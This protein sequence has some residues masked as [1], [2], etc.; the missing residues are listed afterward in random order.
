MTKRLDEL[1]SEACEAAINPNSWAGFYGS[2]RG[3]GDLLDFAKRFPTQSA[4]RG[5]ETF[6]GCVVIA[7]YA[8]WA[9]AQG[10]DQSITHLTGQC[11]RV[12]QKVGDD[13]PWNRLVRAITQ[14]VVAALHYR[15][16]K[17]QQAS[18]SLA[19]AAKHYDS[20]WRISQ[21]KF[22]LKQNAGGED[23]GLTDEPTR[24]LALTFDHTLNDDSG[25][26]AATWMTLHAFLSHLFT[27]KPP[28]PIC[29]NELKVL[30]VGRGGHVLP[31]GIDKVEFPWASL[32]PAFF[33]PLSFGVTDVKTPMRFTLW[34]AARCARQSADLKPDQSL[35]LTVE[36]SPLLHILDG[37]SAGGLFAVGMIATAKE[38]RLDP[39]KTTTCRLWVTP[40]SLIRHPDLL[41]DETL[42]LAFDD[43]ELRPI[44]GVVQK[45]A[46]AWQVQHGLNE[47]LLVP[48]NHDEWF[49]AH[50]GCV[51]PK[52]TPVES[53]GE[54][55]D[56]MWGQQ[57][58]DR[59]LER[60]A[61]AV[62]HRWDD[63]CRPSPLDDN[64]LAD[65]CFRCYVPP[66]LRI[67]GPLLDHPPGEEAKNAGSPRTREEH[68]VPG[69]KDSDEP[70]LNLLALALRSR[71]FE[72]MPKWLMPGRDVVIYDVAGA[73]KTVCSYRL[74]HLLADPNH[75]K[76]LFDRKLPPLV[77]HL[78]DRWPREAVNVGRLLT[79]REV[80]EGRL[81]VE[82]D[83]N[84]PANA[85]L[86]RQT[87]DHAL[88]DRRVVLVVDGLDQF[89]P[90]DREHLVQQYEINPDARLC[91]WVVTSR[92]HTIDDYRGTNRIF[93]D[94]RWMRVRIDPFDDEQQDRYF[95]RVD[96]HGKKIGRRWTE[97]VLDRPAMREL[98]GL[99]MVLWMIRFLIDDADQRGV[100]PPVFESLSRLYVVTSLRLLA[101]AIERNTDPATGQV[102]SR[103]GNRIPTPDGL[104][105][106]QQLTLLEHVLTL[107]AFQMMLITDYNGRREGEDQVAAFERLCKDRFFK[108]LDDKLDQASISTRRKQELEEQLIRDRAHWAWA[109]EVL[110][111][112]ELSH[113]SVTEA[114]HSAGL[115]FRSR[116]MVECHAARYLTRYATSWDI[117]GKDDPDD[118]PV[119][120]LAD[121]SQDLSTFC[122]WN[123]TTDPQWKETWMLAIDMP[124]EPITTHAHDGTFTQAVIDPAVACR[125][126]SA[127]LR[128]PKRYA[129]R[130]IRPTELIYRAWQLFEY[131]DGLM[132]DRSFLVKGKLVRGKG[133]S[134]EDRRDLGQRLLLGSNNRSALVIKLRQDCVA[135][136]RDDKS[137]QMVKEFEERFDTLLADGKRVPIPADQT[138]RDSLLAKWGLRLPRIF[139]MFGKLTKRDVLLAKWGLQSAWEKSRTFIQCPPQSWIDAYESLPEESRKRSNDPRINTAIDGHANESITP[140]RMATTTVTREM[141]RQFDP[142]FESSASKP[143]WGGETLADAI[144]E[145]ASAFGRHTDNDAFPVLCTNFYDAWSFCKWLGP[146]YRLPG[147]FEWEF[148]CRAGTSTLY[149]FG[150][151][152]NGTQ[153]N[154][155][156]N[157]PNAFDSRGN[158]ADIPK[159]PYLQRTTPVGC[160]DYPCNGYGLWDCHGNLWEWSGNW[161][162]DKESFRSLRGGSWLNLASRCCSSYRNDFVP[163]YRGSNF[164]F[165]LV[166]L[167]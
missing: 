156:G 106:A 124:H 42:P 127:L 157:N 41:N 128:Q 92:V 17:P 135:A 38:Q 119:V 142:A 131:D 149:H 122:A 125:S 8:R 96:P 117:F 54:L 126:L 70:L 30:T 44:R 74:C 159:G 11:L 24:L 158:R 16:H 155:D 36:A 6:P 151:S 67:E 113:R 138:Q 129:A 51:T 99:P 165:R 150:N 134:A 9:L 89:P 68:P 64:R 37:R 102:K 166:C 12:L 133:L 161:Y 104:Q 73:G 40:E 121:P 95:D 18:K 78:L 146:Q 163:A 35:R 23:L 56:G 109:I 88:R 164:G 152:L 130:D 167:V 50:P 111:T 93:D 94:R 114:Y 4:Q 81:R 103:D 69:A 141:Y 108:E 144:N 137:R 7:E 52:I 1:L 57:R 33:D 62:R 61:E 39:Q 162:D 60:H 77:I 27:T 85:E 112:I 90:E 20:V 47:F 101:R 48:K 120:N 49:A 98:L 147:D 97:A 10:S 71:P 63:A 110:K 139:K 136:F 123:Y 105:P 26:T 132:L 31:I 21:K 82:A 140:F 154:C 115:V 80:L 116:K 5:A 59:E 13:H 118:M 2:W 3:R 91:R 58:F 145:K 22:P 86:V 25:V 153:A 100:A 87:I 72:E 45:L 55:L 83:R 34:L 75:W 15:N 46:E 148:A 43:L 160:V 28:N 65:H 84:T 14:T 53:F 76:A 19:D 66:S 29:R 79:L 107:L 143:N 32:Y